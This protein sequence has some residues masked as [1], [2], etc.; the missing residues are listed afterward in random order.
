M[1]DGAPEKSVIKKNVIHFTWA[2]LNDTFV[3]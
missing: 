3:A 1:F 2:T